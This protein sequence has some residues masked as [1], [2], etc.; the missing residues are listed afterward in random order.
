MSFKITSELEAAL[1]SVGVEGAIEFTAPP[2]AEMGDF[3]FACFGIAKT[4][5]KSPVEVAKELEL[6][7]KNE[8]LRMVSDV[9]AVGSYV[10]FFLNGAEVARMVIEE[11]TRRGDDYGM[12]EIGKGKKV[13]VEFAHP[14]THKAF[15]IGH[16]R[17]IV[18]GE[19]LVRIL[20]N[21]GYEVVRANYQGDVGMHI[22]KCLWGVR[23]LR[24]EYETVKNKTITE[25][26]A[27]LGKAYALGSQTFEQDEKV[28][29]EIGEINESI[30]THD[31]SIREMYT[32]TRGWSLEY[33]D[34]I[35]ARVGSRF[36]RLYFES[37][38]FARGREIV[39]ECVVKEIFVQSEGAV[40]FK[41]SEFGLHDR[42]FLN[43][44]GFPTYEA[45]DLALAEKQFAEFDPV[46]IYHVVAKEQS[47]YF[48][49]LFKALEFTL[50]KSKERERHLEYGWVKLKEGKMSSRTGKVVLGEWLLDEA[51]KEVT[52]IMSESDLPN[53]DDVIKNVALA[54][55]KYAFL[56]TGIENDIAFDFKTSVSLTGD[57]GPYLLY[58]CARIRS[59]LEKIGTLSLGEIPETIVLEEKRLLLLLGEFG[60]VT[61]RAAALPDP[62]LIAHY[63]LVLAQRFSDFYAAC[64]VVKSEG[65]T[66][67]FRAQLIK[68]VLT[69]AKRG[70]YLLGIKVVEKM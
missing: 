44:K 60:A 61:A 41:G 7:I 39:K 34:A 54:A 11:I 19:S 5:K 13:I 10:N 31:E 12:G 70:L 15:H 68:S 21:A 14:N 9:R 33:F 16:L 2:K 25:R 63:L 58:M 53:K 57:S 6:R 8:E 26:V 23:Q 69:V 46:A 59:I 17:N 30:Y 27:F 40:I 37:E 18:T 24:A 36:D 4:Q 45:K 1:R 47:E 66:R 29:A 50:P 20:E 48:K 32:E 67:I 22:A 49:V 62:S 35:Y 64:S 42:V 55:V 52:Q 28:K 3:A 56:K 43:S 65:A 38:V 51:E